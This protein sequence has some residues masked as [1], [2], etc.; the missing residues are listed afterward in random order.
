ITDAVYRSYNDVY[1]CPYIQNGATDSRNFHRI[2]PNVYRF[3]MFRMSGAERQAIH[4]NNE[5]IRLSS[6][7]EGITAYINLFALLNES[8][9]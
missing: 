2:F 1:C 3:A 6:Y 7:Y 8:Q 9:E 4:G 5:R